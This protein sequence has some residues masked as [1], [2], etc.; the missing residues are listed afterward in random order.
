MYRAAVFEKPNNIVLT[1][2]PKPGLEVNEVLIKVAYAGICNTDLSIFSG[3]YQVP[4]LPLVLGHEFTGEI[5]EVG[6]SSYDDFLGKRVTAEINNTCIAY[7]REVKCPACNK[8]LNHHCS[9]RT[10]L[11]IIESDGAFA[12]YVKVPI[13][14]IH[15]LPEEVSL[16]EGTFVE[17]LAA[18]FQTFE[19]APVHPEDLVIIY[20]LGKLGVLICSV[21]KHLGARVLA[22]SRS[23]EKLDRAKE[24][25]ADFTLTPTDD[26]R[27]LVNSLTNNL[28]A[29]KVVE[30]TGDPQ[31]LSN[32]LNVVRP[33]GTIV[34]KTTTSIPVK[35]LDSTKI[36][37]DEIKLVGSR[38][39]PFEKAIKMLA[40]KVIEV[41]SLISQVYPLSE[42]QN[43]LK[44][45]R[46]KLK[47][48]IEAQ[49]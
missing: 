18:A 6:D 34:L 49:T 25:G 22:V 16:K 28:G 26:V 40:D 7:R 43:A 12:E 35:N 15:V 47:I 2:K 4:F 9:K 20:G 46:K 24:F 8:G 32:C 44:A 45:A 36:V 41:D 13:G 21:A 14:N 23:K 30:A 19:M 1:E 11:G 3:E 27:S 48:L 38:C 5:T 33:R 10:V 31:V 37:L 39:G 17:P 29:D 42:I